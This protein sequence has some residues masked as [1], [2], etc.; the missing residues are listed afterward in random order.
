[1]L[2]REYMPED[3]EFVY[4]LSEREFSRYGPNYGTVMVR[5]IGRIDTVALVAE[6]ESHIPVGFCIVEWERRHGYVA[7]IAVSR[8]ARHKGV[9]RALLDATIKDG[10]NRNHGNPVALWLHVSENNRGG[11]QFF[12]K[13]GFQLMPGTDFQYENGDMSLIM[14]KLAFPE[15]SQSPNSAS[16]AH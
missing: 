2:V 9:A 14:T 5:H 7:A 6:D 16:G 15:D 1:M 13:F 12:E 11:R 10:L 3:A 8:E 4:A